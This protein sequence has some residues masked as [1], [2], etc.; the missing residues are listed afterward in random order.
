L[1]LDHEVLHSLHWRWWLRP[2]PVEA[3]EPPVVVGRALNPHLVGVVQVWSWFG[4]L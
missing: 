2:R 3:S 4:L 1:G